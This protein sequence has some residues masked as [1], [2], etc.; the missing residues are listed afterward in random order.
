MALADTPKDF[1]LD[2][3]AKS[4]H[5][6]DPKVTGR[7]PSQ[8]TYRSLDFRPPDQSH[9][10]LGDFGKILKQFHAGIMISSPQQWL[11]DWVPRVPEHGD[12]GR[13]YTA[14]RYVCMHSPHS[15]GDIEITSSANLR[16]PSTCVGL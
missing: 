16:T 11:P 15:T 5:L 7:A 3:R 2:K 9:S 10:L 6:K 13:R 12:K 4:E 8:G 1:I 14:V